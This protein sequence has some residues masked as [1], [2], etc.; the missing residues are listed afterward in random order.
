MGSYNNK[1]GQAILELAIFGTIILTIFG[2]L[3][4]F[5]QRF[6]DQQ[7]VQMEAFRRT[8]EKS[9]TYL[10]ETSEGAGASVQL[11]FL[12]DRRHADLAG[13]LGKGS[14]TTLSASSSVFWAVPKVGAE[15][16]SLIVFRVNEDERTRNYRDFVPKE[17]DDDWSFRTE[18]MTTSSNLDFDETIT[19]SETDQA[20]TNTRSSSL[21]ETKTTVIPYTVRKKDKDDDDENDEIVKDKEGKDKKGT[22]WENYDGVGEDGKLIQRLHRDSQGQYKYSSK[23]SEGKKVERSRTWTTNFTK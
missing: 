20:I 15:S 22:F 14:G 11:T 17:H 8:L 23:V 4:S 6:N 7:Y 5:L 10:G 2:V 18:D 13:G 3:L 1:K 9:C 21:S 12:E 19:K 16:E